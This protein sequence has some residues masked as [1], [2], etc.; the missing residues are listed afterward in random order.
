MA[1]LAH[2]LSLPTAVN[3]LWLVPLWFSPSR[4]L[5]AYPWDG[6]TCMICRSRESMLAVLDQGSCCGPASKQG[7]AVQAA[8]DARTPQAAEDAAGSHKAAGHVASPPAFQSLQIQAP[9]CNP[10]PGQLLYNGTL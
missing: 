5:L 1:S 2:D 8:A 10:H 3:R 4:L 7:V 9:C 6:Q